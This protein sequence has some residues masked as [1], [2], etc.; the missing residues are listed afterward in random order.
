VQGVVGSGMVRP[1][2]HGKTAIGLGAVQLALQLVFEKPSFVNSYLP[3]A[4]SFPKV[5]SAVHAVACVVLLMWRFDS[6]C[7][8]L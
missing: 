1:V 6:L 2:E 7:R 8:I 4:S 3:V 5:S